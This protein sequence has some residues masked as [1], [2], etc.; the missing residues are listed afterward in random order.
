MIPGPGVHAMKL[1]F[2]TYCLWKSRH[3]CVRL[4]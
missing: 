4:P 2:E 1:A 3:G